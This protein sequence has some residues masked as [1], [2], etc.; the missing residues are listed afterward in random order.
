MTQRSKELN[1][2][3][4]YLYFIDVPEWEAEECPRCGE[5]MSCNWKNGYG[6]YYCPEGCDITIED[7]QDNPKLSCAGVE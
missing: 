5:A 1:L 2:P 7:I 4:G 3:F 6:Y